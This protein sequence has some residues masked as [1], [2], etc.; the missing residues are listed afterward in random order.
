MI[1]HRYT[2]KSILLCRGEDGNRETEPQLETRTVSPLIEPLMPLM[3]YVPAI[4]RLANFVCCE[5]R[6]S[7]ALSITAGPRPRVAP[8]STS[9][10]RGRPGL[11]GLALTRASFCDLPRPGPLLGREA[12]PFA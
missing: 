4:N 9:E 1:R 12:R 10:P 7:T 5:A 11:P 8:P 3:N 2:S 6:L